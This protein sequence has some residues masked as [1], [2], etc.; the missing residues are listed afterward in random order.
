MRYLVCGFIA[1]IVAVS[2]LLAGSSV[3]SASPRKAIVVVSFGTT[4]DDARKACI[5]AVEDQIR[6]A[7]PTYDVR[8][9]F[10]S[11]IIMKRLGDRGIMVNDLERTLSNLKDEGYQDIVIQPTHLTPGEEYDKKVVAVVDQYR[12]SFKSVV[13]SRPVLMFDGQNN[14]PNDYE[15]AAKALKNQL[16]KLKAGEEVVFMGHGSPHQHNPAYQRLQEE[17]DHAKL[18]ITIGVVEETDYPNLEDVVKRLAAKKSVKSI[19]LMPLMLVAGD[20]A[21]NDMAGDEEDSWKN[22]L[23]EQGYRINGTYLHGLGENAAFR[24]IYVRHIKDAIAGKYSE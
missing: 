4:F 18:P 13:I 19:T 23:Q 15:V 5:Q 11:K 12:A 1:V 16:P 21:N 3:V 6:D 17:I 8:R 7:F 20:H 9:A 24:A 10:T 14:T 22:T 2:G